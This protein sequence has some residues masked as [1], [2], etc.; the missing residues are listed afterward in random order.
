MFGSGAWGAAS[1]QQSKLS[2]G[3]PFLAA[4]DS[5]PPR[6]IVTVV[7]E[8]GCKELPRG[9]VAA[10]S[11]LEYLMLEGPVGKSNAEYRRELFLLN[12][13]IS[14]SVA[15]R[16]VLLVVTAPPST[17]KAA[18]QISSELVQK[19]KLV[20]DQLQIAQQRSISRRRAQ[21]QDMRFLTD[22]AAQRYLYPGHPDA[23]SCIS[24]ISDIQGLGLEALKSDWAVLTQPSRRAFGTVG[25]MPIAA[26]RTLI[27]A[28]LLKD[29]KARYEAGAALEP[30]TFRKPSSPSGTDVVLLEQPEAQ[31]NQ[32]LY[33]WPHAL[34][35][36]TADFATAEIA[37]TLLGGGFTGRLQQ[38]LRE[39]RGLTY[40]AFADID[41]ELPQYIG[42]SFAGGEKV[43]RLIQELP[44]VYAAFVAEQQTDERIGIAKEALVTSFRES[45]EL[46]L[47]SF[48]MALDA[49]FYGRDPNAWRGR[50]ER[51][52]A[53]T[54]SGLEQFIRARMNSKPSYLIVAGDSK[55]L[56]PVLEQAGYAKESIKTLSADEL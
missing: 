14:M 48:L 36:D 2:N 27:E 41:D 23:Y 24:K 16:G 50:A 51:W 43:A 21:Q 4:V 26:V 38:E 54:K 7:Y 46:P 13:S 37:F 55:V 53:V 6:Q 25:P 22:L 33:I 42:A 12:A 29:S 31:D 34:K 39:K 11:L 49:R 32:V 10:A 3:S 52:A 35:A 44:Q 9:H 28:T 5:G 18:L 15:G 19:P 20:E 17:L 1:V 45:T 47:D 56:L 40:G 30:A 8:T